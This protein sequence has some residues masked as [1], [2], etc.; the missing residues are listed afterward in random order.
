MPDTDAS[1]KP[2][3]RVK[4]LSTAAKNIATLSRASV[5][6]KKYQADVRQA[7]RQELL[8][9]QAQE[10]EASF[11]AGGMNEEQVM[12]WRKKFLGVQ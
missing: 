12:F 8:N 5:N 4:L 3:Q 10:L 1:I 7:I 9:E 6:L 2:E 11:K